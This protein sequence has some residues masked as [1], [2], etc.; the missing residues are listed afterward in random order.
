MSAQNPEARRV[1]VLVI[2]CEKSRERAETFRAY[3]AR[4]VTGGHAVQSATKMRIT[5]FLN[6]VVPTSL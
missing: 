5:E 1:D 4:L 3:K 6:Q 2:L